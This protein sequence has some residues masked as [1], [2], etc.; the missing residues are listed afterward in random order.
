MSN[1]DHFELAEPEQPHELTIED[2]Y[3]EILWKLSQND[4]TYISMNPEDS[5]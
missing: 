3:N 5:L 4:E 1:I 2:E